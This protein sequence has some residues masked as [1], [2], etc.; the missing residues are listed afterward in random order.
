MAVFESFLLR[1]QHFEYAK[2]TISNQYR[3][4]PEP[5]RPSERSCVCPAQQMNEDGEA[6]VATHQEQSKN[7]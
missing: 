2:H 7:H 5:N 4:R 3:V 6:M 1:E